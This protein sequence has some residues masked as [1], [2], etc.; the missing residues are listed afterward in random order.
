[1]PTAQQ[2]ARLARFEA[3]SARHA[4]VPIV[5]YRHRADV[6]GLLA[7]IPPSAFGYIVVPILLDVDDWVASAAVTFPGAVT[8]VQEAKLLVP[9]SQLLV[10]STHHWILNAGYAGLLL[11][12]RNLT[13]VPNL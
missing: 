8:P 2:A 9:S 13:C 10:P 3:H 12:A 5:R 4:R 7:T 6:P 1:M 11:R